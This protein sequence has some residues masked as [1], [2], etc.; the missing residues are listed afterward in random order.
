MLVGGIDESVV[1]LLHRLFCNGDSYLCIHKLQ[2]WPP[3]IV[4]LL[5]H[6]CSVPTQV[7]VI[8]VPRVVVY[9]ARI[10]VP[11]GP[12]RFVPTVI[13]RLCVASSIVLLAPTS[14]PTSHSILSPVAVI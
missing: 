1:N 5:L 8:D 3:S 11:I 9:L 7:K 2:D 10:C 6:E 13:A 4:N 12:A 14:P